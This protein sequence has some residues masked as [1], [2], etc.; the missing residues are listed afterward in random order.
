MERLKIDIPDYKIQ[1]TAEV[2]LVNKVLRIR[3]IDTNGG[4][5]TFLKDIKAEFKE[6]QKTQ[7]IIMQFFGHKNENELEVDLPTEILNS[8]NSI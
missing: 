1:R 6:D 7:H 4:P 5:Y 3:G 8:N 2:K